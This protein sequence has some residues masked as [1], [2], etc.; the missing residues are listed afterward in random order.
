MGLHV[1]ATGQGS[2]TCAV[3]RG[4][5]EGEAFWETTTTVVSDSTWLLPAFSLLAARLR[6]PLEIQGSVDAAALRGAESALAL[7]TR[8]YPWL[9]PRGIIASSVTPGGVARPG[10]ACFFSG[11]V[12]SWYS[13][14]THRDELDALIFVHG[15]DIPVD[16]VDLG[17][18]A[19]ESARAAAQSLGLPLVEVRTD[20]RRFIDPHLR[21]DF[22]Y[23]GAALATV[24]HLLSDR[25]GTVLIPASTQ[26]ASLSRAD[27]R[28]WGSSVALDHRWSSSRLRIIHDGPVSRAVK[29][30][31]IADWPTAMERLRVCW[32]NPD[33]A[34]NCGRCEKCLRTMVNLRT[35]GAEGRCMTLPGHVD[36]KQVEH[37]P[38][39][40]SGLRSAREN[41]ELTRERGVDEEL[42]AALR[43]LIR[44]GQLERARSAPRATAKWVLRRARLRDRV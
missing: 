29:V 4:L 11:G 26:P 21:W 19:L 8:W 39:P 9:R 33:G 34:H 16:D 37:L 32:Q 25:F 36:A 18:R 15:F 5:V 27:R 41:L 43:T 20:I 14:L 30:A 28:P 38:L 1:A 44:R 6:T 10:M 17:V 35:A 3:V 31:A 12:D 23:H 24:A 40:R 22:E 13:V 42:E 7:M 2:R